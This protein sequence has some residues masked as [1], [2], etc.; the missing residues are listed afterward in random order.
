MPVAL[1]AGGVTED[2]L[3]LQHKLSTRTGR[4]GFTSNKSGAGE[5]DQKRGEGP[6]GCARGLSLEVG[7]NR[8]T[9]RR[10]VSKD[11][12]SLRAAGMV[13]DRYGAL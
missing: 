3:A 2:T 13:A 1:G 9:E 6:H 12:V 8:Q 5:E 4:R 7:K 10:S 11:A